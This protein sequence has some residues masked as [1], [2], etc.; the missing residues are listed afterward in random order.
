MMIESE[1]KG[2]SNAIGIT[3][4]D[5]VDVLL[6]NQLHDAALPPYITTMSAEYAGLSRTGI[7]LIVVAHGVGPMMTPV[8]V[9]EFY[10]GASNRMG[11]KERGFW[12]PGFCIKFVKISG[13]GPLTEIRLGLNDSF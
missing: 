13:D 6:Q 10:D 11:Y 4:H 9:Q 12:K 2:S 5:I 7:P 3:I 8:L 1:I